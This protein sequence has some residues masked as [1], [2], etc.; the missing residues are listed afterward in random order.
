[1]ALGMKERWAI[2][3]QTRLR[4]L[5][6]RVDLIVGRMRAQ[7]DDDD[8]KLRGTGGFVF[9]QLKT[10]KEILRKLTRLSILVVCP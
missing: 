10:S 5:K 7:M 6:I 9:E 4:L 2:G 1:M 8:A 3:I